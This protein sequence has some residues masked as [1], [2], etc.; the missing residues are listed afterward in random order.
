[1]QALAWYFVAASYDGETG[2][3]RHS[4][5]PITGW[6]Q[7]PSRIV[8]ERSTAVRGV[9]SS[10]VPFLL[11]RY[12]EGPVSERLVGGHFNGKIDSP[13]LF[14][15]ALRPAELES[16]K[17]RASPKSLGEALIAEWDIAADFSSRK[18][19]DTTSHGLHSHTVNMPAKAMS[20]HNWT[21]NEI[22]YNRAPEEY[23]AIHFHDDDLDDAGWEVDF[24][25]AVTEQLRSGVYP[26]R[27]RTGE[28]EDYV[29]FF[30][31]PKKGTATAR[32]AFLVPTF[33]YLAYG[34][35]HMAD[36][37]LLET[38]NPR[39]V[40]VP[41]P[42]QV[43]DKY[44][45]EQKLSSLY[46]THTD[47]S[48]VCYSSRLRPI[49]NMRS[50]YGAAKLSGS[51]HQF[52]ADLHLVDWLEAMGHSFDVV[53]VEDLHH[54]GE[55]LLAPYK[56]VL[57]DSHPENWLGQMLDGLESYLN[58]GGRLMYLGGNG[59]YWV[60][61]MGPERRHTVEVRRWIGTKSWI[62]E[63]GEVFHSTA[64][65]MGDCG[66]FGAGLPRRQ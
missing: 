12:W 46:D 43:Q 8:V 41:Y 22:N 47:G 65:E 27:L 23:G 53:T 37:E 56:V 44:I 58:H 30:V 14:G 26:A 51:P 11:G 15:Q 1:M 13:R 3:V 33:S 9:G 32:I 20:G 49:L 39:L 55:D 40:G 2:Q 64:G 19:T 45:V 4:Q 5:E 50:K 62:A 60:T 28:G 24:E 6:S 34:N 59:F 25:L 18:V 63:P 57:T 35:E 36:M 10:N 16:L 52:N 21:G 54:E 29:P 48:G 17:G 38:L 7:D 42:E 31:R 66:V 61:S